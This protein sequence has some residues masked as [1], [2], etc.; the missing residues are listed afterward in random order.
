[1]GLPPERL[2][3]EGTSLLDS[4]KSISDTLVRALNQVR[5]NENCS[6]NFVHP[7]PLPISSALDDPRLLTLGV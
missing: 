2:S 3:A 5:M 6:T 7:Y 1:M 4:R